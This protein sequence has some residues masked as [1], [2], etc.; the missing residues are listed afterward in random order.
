MT[1]T[2]LMPLVNWISIFASLAVVGVAAAWTGVQAWSLFRRGLAAQSSIL[3][4]TT[5]LA[6]R[7]AVAVRRSESLAERSLE[8]N[9]SLGE[10]QRS[11]G[12]F[13]VLVRAAQEAS[14]RWRR[15]T[16]FVR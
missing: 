11:L 15:F 12:R 14:Q 3:P 6:E 4:L 9:E 5:G 2:A 10:F 1:A 7:A 16:G 8:F 13:R